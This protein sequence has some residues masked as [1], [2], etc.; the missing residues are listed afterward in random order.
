MRATL[1]SGV[2]AHSCRRGVPEPQGQSLLRRPCAERGPGPSATTTAAA[3]GRRGT[4][5]EA[6]EA[7]MLAAAQA[8]IAFSKAGVTLRHGRSSPIGAHF[9]VARGLSNAMLFPAAT[10]FSV[11]AAES[12]HADCPRTLGVAADGDGDALA[13]GRFVWALRDLCEDLEVPTPQVNGIAKAEWFSLSP[14]VAEQA[15]AS[16]FSPPTIPLGPLSTRSRTSARRSTAEG[17]RLRNGDGT[18]AR[19]ARS[20]R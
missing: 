10:A 19:S 16:G 7:M 1:D 4:D 11:P 14:L 5:S 8:G 6:R 15:P 13:A 2:D 18:T 9:H 3:S 12:R 20:T 17:R